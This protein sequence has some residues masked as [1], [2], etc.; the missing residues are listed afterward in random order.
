VALAT[1]PSGVTENRPAFLPITKGRM[2]FLIRLL[3]DNYTRN[4]LPWGRAVGLLRTE[5][6]P[7]PQNLES[8]TQNTGLAPRCSNRQGKKR[9]K[10]HHHTKLVK[11]T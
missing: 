2:A 4:G 6:A 10:G 7:T 3:P 1:A 11:S 8:Y 5:G 9:Q